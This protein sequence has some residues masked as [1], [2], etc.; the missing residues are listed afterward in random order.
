MLLDCSFDKIR[1]FQSGSHRNP[2]NSVASFLAQVRG[3]TKHLFLSAKD[4]ASY[5]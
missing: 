1:E 4:I 5:L 3:S 2:A